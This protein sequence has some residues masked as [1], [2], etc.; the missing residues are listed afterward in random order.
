MKV[1]V[2][3][4]GG[5]LGREIVEQLIIAG[6][7]VVVVSRGQTT[8]SEFSGNVQFIRCDINDRQKLIKSF[9]G[10]ETVVHSAALSAPWGERSD[11][12]KQNVE[13]TASVVSA[14]EAAGVRRLIHVS[15]S[16]VYFSYEDKRDIR[17]NSTLPRP[18]NAY[19]ESKQ[20][21]ENAASGFKGEA[22]IVRP[23]GIYGPGDLHLLPRLLR[24]MKQRPLPLLRGG[25]A[26]VDITDVSVVADAVLRMIE[27]EQTKSGI[28]NISHGEP[29]AIS[30]LVQEISDGLDI[31]YRWRSLPMAVAFAGARI[32]EAAA[33]FD[34]RRS[35]P[36]V[37]AYGLGL[38]GYSHT[39][40]ISKAAR[41]LNW[42]PKLSLREGLQ[43]TFLHFRETKI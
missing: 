23:R 26:L 33:R 6:H 16:S 20:K 40:D 2:T 30:K 27:V 36:L 25:K 15:S 5:F 8:S 3:G 43:R 1:A 7:E 19:A 17:E 35:E 18:V 37:T 14:A 13:G 29:I 41:A 38:F 10:C 12:Q 34:P 39:L 21:A 24:V 42:K 28:Y 4:G 22:F 31:P 11:F 32:L 9:E